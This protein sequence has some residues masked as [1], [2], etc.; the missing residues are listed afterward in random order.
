MRPVAGGLEIVPGATVELKPE[1]FHL[2]I[3]NVKQPIEKGKPFAATLTFEKAGTVDVE[4]AVE[5]TGAMSP[6]QT[7]MPDMPHMHH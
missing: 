2:M 7:S 3:T 6:G 4:F 5:G 1:S